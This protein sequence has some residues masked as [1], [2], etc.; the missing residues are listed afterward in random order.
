MVRKLR[1]KCMLVT[2]VFGK[3][4]DIMPPRSVPVVENQAE[5]SVNRRGN[6]QRNAQAPPP[7]PPRDPATRALEGMARLF[8]QQVQQQQLQQQQLQLQLQQMQQ[9]QLQ[10]P[11]RPPRDV[12]DQFRRLA[13][14]EFSGT[15]DPFAAEGWIHLKYIFATSIWEMRTE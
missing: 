10:Q 13:P 15:T 3:R 9:Q 6:S 14:K 8:E 12:Y 5:N 2:L 11:P 4:S 1:F 7:P